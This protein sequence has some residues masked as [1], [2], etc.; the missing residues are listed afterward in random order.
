M[1]RIDAIRR[2]VE[3]VGSDRCQQS[4]ASMNELRVFARRLAI[5]VLDVN[6]GRERRIGTDVQNKVEMLEKPR[7]VESEETG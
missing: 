3:P 6:V 1:G 4:P 5:R 7:L 2:G